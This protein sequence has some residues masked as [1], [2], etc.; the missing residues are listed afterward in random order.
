MRIVAGELGGR[1]LRAPRGSATRPTSD[2]ARESLFARLGPIDGLAAIDP[3]AGTGALGLEALSRG[4]ASCIF[5]ET[6]HAA[7]ACLRENI[8]TLGM[9]DRSQVQRIDGARLL[10][11]EAA[12][13]RRFG[14]VLLDPPYTLLP[15]LL[16]AL[17]DLV[18]AVAAPGALIA[19]EAPTGLDVD[20][21]PGLEHRSTTRTGAAVHHLFAAW[22]SSNPSRH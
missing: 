2:R 1:R 4:A 15:R 6:G 13:G 8:E 5:S 12:A 21:G 3:F 19:L 22:P 18:E 14:L 11:N 17:G 7:L 10:R 9:A 20:L 16:P